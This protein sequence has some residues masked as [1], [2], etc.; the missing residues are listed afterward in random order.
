MRHWVLELSY[1]AFIKR[2]GFAGWESKIYK[3]KI[4]KSVLAMT[5]MKLDWLKKN[6]SIVKRGSKILVL[7][8]TPCGIENC[9]ECWQHSSGI[10]S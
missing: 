7:S 5:I 10:V 1:I 6:K 9:F 2:N 8:C 3:V 4:V